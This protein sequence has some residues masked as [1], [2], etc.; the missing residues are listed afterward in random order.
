MSNAQNFII[1]YAKKTNDKD[2]VAVRNKLFTMRSK[3][4]NMYQFLVSEYQGLRSD[5]E[6]EHQTSKSSDPSMMMSR[7][8]FS[9]SVRT[10]MASSRNIPS[11]YS[12]V[13]TKMASYENIPRDQDDSK[14]TNM[15][16]YENIPQTAMRYGPND[17]DNEL[18]ELER[19]AAEARQKR[20]R[21]ARITTRML[22]SE[23]IPQT[24]TEES[25]V[26][27]NLSAGRLRFLKGENLKND[28]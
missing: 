10:R 4:P 2:L 3:N 19:K 6:S 17:D 20:S 5:E 21:P 16:S 22:K 24:T 15:A 7:M 11:E 12:G 23:N 27:K 13:M 1:W 28:Y 8:D 26:P 14:V 18:A 25:N 9:S